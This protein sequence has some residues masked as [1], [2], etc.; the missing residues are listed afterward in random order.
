M[1]KVKCPCLRNCPDRH[2][3]CHNAECKHGWATY[4]KEYHKN[5]LEIHRE[6][7]ALQQASEYR[8]ERVRKCLRRKMGGRKSLPLK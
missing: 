4:E 7:I 8:E 6:K 1:K 2:P 3:G 5:L